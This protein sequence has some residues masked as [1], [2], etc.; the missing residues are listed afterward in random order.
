[1]EDIPG[2][3]E[4][5][6]V[7]IEPG[8]RHALI[9]RL[10]ETR[11]SVD[12]LRVLVG[13][14]EYDLY[15]VLADVGYRQAPRTRVDRAETFT[16]SNS[17]W[18]DAMPVSASRTIRAIASQF[19]I[20]GTEELE[21]L[22]I[23]QTPAVRLAGGTSALSE[24]GDAAQTYHRNETP[25]VLRVSTNSRTYDTTAQ[26]QTVAARLAVGQARR[27]VRGDSRSYL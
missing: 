8:K 20:G 26:G 23:F 12:A 21:N 3:D 14:E 13:M 25:D 24:Y 6:E 2:L 7:W 10:S 16:A 15:D 5:R 1:M 22:G 17:D 27:G 11:Q 9:Q 4:F 19:A 18:L